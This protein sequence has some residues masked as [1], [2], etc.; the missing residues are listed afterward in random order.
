VFFALFDDEHIVCQ[1][2]S[3][4]VQLAERFEARKEL[5]RKLLLNESDVLS[6]ILDLSYKDLFACLIAINDLVILQK[7]IIAEHVLQHFPLLLRPAPHS[8]L[9]YKFN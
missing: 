8:P 1:H 4:L 2:Y 3:I 5:R 7:L 9:L 6:A